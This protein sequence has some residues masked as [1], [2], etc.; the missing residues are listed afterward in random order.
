MLTSVLGCNLW[1]I[2]ASNYKYQSEK[3][4]RISA[5]YFERVIPGE[6]NDSRTYSRHRCCF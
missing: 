2:Y 6:T 4:G 1:L 5:D 3:M